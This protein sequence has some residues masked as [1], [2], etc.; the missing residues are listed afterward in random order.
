MV[1]SVKLCKE[2][3][4]NGVENYHGPKKAR[5]CDSNTPHIKKVRVVAT[6]EYYLTD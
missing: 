1:R 3:T 4:T 2:P 6:L 5:R